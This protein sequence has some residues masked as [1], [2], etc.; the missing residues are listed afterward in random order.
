MKN[1][2]EVSNTT[3]EVEGS[4]PHGNQGIFAEK[5]SFRPVGRLG[6][7]GK[8]NSCHTRLKKIWVMILEKTFKLR[9]GVKN[10]KYKR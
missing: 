7:F 5:Q 1:S 8:N 3:H 9:E 6:E 10:K 4:I 2:P